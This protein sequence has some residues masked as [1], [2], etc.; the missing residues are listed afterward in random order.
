MASP[1]R[2]FD[3][4]VSTVALIL[5]SPLIALVAVAVRLRLGSPVLFRQTRPGKDGELFEILKFR[6][7][8]DATDPSRST[9]DDED[10][11]TKF[12][13]KLRASSLDELPELLNII[14]GDM[15]LVGPRPLLVDYLPRYDQ[16]Q[17]RRH[18]VK[19][20]L[21]GWAQIHGRNSLSWQDKF[22]LDVWYVDNRSFRL[23]LR[24]IRETL[25]GVIRRDGISADGTA[26]AF[27]F[28]GND[29]PD[30]DDI[31]IVLEDNSDCLLYTSPS[32]RD[33]QKSRMPSS[34]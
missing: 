1:K 7:M 6:T 24:I 10:R 14:R 34:A 30:N 33:R 23:D 22:E 16:T 13:A 12:G 20:G 32:P 17:A 4:V 28:L 25:R 31:E 26:T 9:L 5:L 8:R 29:R 2:A 19:P 21:T 18:E 3:A 27:H 11:L 15:S